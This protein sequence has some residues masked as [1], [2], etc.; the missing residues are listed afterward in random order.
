VNA[1]AFVPCGERV[2]VLLKS[3]G[4]DVNALKYRLCL[5]LV[6]RFILLKAASAI[7]ELIP[8][9]FTLIEWLAIRKKAKD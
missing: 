5:P 2:Q 1:F 9:P 4:T 6:K 7:N 8:Y 3:A